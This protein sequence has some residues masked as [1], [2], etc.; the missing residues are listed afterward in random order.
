MD[1][2]RAYSITLTTRHASPLTWKTW[3]SRRN[4]LT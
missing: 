2:C 4:L 1:G 3:N